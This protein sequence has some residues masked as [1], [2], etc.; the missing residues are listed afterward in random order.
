[1][2]GLVL[3]DVNRTAPEPEVVPGVRIFIHFISADGATV[4]SGGVETQ[5]GKLGSRV[6]ATSPSKNSSQGDEGLSL[7]PATINGFRSCV[8]AARSA[9]HACP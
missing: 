8:R 4:G 2:F 1:M 3:L 6:S 7:L 5:F 9:T